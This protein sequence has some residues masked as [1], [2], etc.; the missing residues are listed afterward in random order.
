MSDIPSRPVFRKQTGDRLVE[1]H[2]RGKTR[3][4]Y[5]G[6]CLLQSQMA[7]HAP[8][9]LQLPYTQSMMFSLLLVNRPGRVLLIGLGAGSLVRFLHHHFPHCRI[10]SVDNS[11]LI[12]K[13]ARGYFGLPD[14]ENIRVHCL[15]GSQYLSRQE[16]SASYDLILL[17]A[18]DEQGMAVRLYNP[19][20]FKRCAEL[21][22]PAGV[23]CVNAW[24]GGAKTVAGLAAELQ[25]VFSWRLLLPV[26]GRGNV[27]LLS[28]LQPLDWRAL[29]RSK[30]ELASLSQQF[31]LDFA[32]LVATARRHN[33]TVGQRL[34]QFLG[35]W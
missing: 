31:S 21:L 19:M 9:L 11:A 26:P 6:G 20:V 3:S 24:S 16:L 1:I 29:C 2:D 15:D 12:I 27:I 18:F 25:A 34:R 30:E 10:D 4:L 32:E 14:S 7:L 35:W 17:D 22:S 33:L 28:S 5:F 13:L 23:F 8:H